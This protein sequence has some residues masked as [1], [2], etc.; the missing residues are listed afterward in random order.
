MPIFRDVN[1]FTGDTTTRFTTNTKVE[2]GKEDQNSDGGPITGKDWF[3]KLDS[4]RESQK[5]KWRDMAALTIPSI[6]LEEGISE[7]E[8]FETPFQ[9]L[10]ARAVNTLSSK[11]T[12]ALLPAASPFYKM[13]LDQSLLNEFKNQD[14]GI[15]DRISQALLQDSNV[16]DQF[17][18]STNVRVTLYQILRKLIVL[19]NALPFV[20]NDGNTKVIP[21][22]NYVNLRDGS[23]EFTL[24][25]VKELVHPNTV[26][27]EGVREFLKAHGEGNSS[28]NTSNTNLALKNSVEMFTVIELQ[29]DG[30]RYR[31]FQEAGGMKIPGKDSIIT[32][33][34]CPYLPPLTWSL[35]QGENYGRSH[36]E[37]HLGDFRSFEGLSQLMVKGTAA[38]AKLTP[39][40]DP[41]GLT[42]VSD[43]TR[44]ETGEPVLGREGDVVMLQAGNKAVDFRVVQETMN[45][46][47]RRISEAFLLNSSV[48]RDA[49]RVTAEEIRILAQELD[50]S[51]GGSFSNLR[52]FQDPYLRR[53]MRILKDQKKIAQ[54]ADKDLKPQIITGIEALGR[55]H[56]LEKLNN[57][58]GLALQI[59]GAEDYLNT[60]GILD[61]I[62]DKV[63]IDQTGI[64]LGEEEVS[65]I[66][67]QRQQA[68]LMSKAAG[69]AI[70]QATK[71]IGDAVNNQ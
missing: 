66:R 22:L 28:N 7:E 52:S 8:E 63:Q 44:S 35:I 23:G 64:L 61:K 30:K 68:E 37:D 70:G 43:L 40:V 46:I 36:V 18:N 53:I 29:D 71:A 12:L 59:P 26:R 4:L 19:G 1:S 58:I 34:R 45:K 41:N 17:V 13:L 11:L 49:E 21:P 10:G 15:E 60:K 55:G 54:V 25:V 24:L 5:R 57:F 65:Q 47:E 9:S 42:T 38:L 48:Q 39:L 50:E 16:I 27:E 67:E 6:M 62:A 51:L 3:N 2:K 33:D 56:E 32:K 20:G 14:P 69:P 31:V